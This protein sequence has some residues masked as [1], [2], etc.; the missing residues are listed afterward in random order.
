MNFPQTLARAIRPLVRPPLGPSGLLL[1]VLFAAAPA[2]A[3]ELPIEVEARVDQGQIYFGENVLYQVVVQNAPQSPAPDLSALEKDFAIERAG[4]Q[5][6]VLNSQFTQRV[7]YGHSYQYRL[8]PKRAGRLTIAAPTVTFEGRKY[9]G[10][11]L[12]LSVIAPEVQDL[13]LVELAADA[14]RAFPSLPITLTV[15][16]LLKPLAEGMANEPLPLMRPPSL[17]IPWLKKAPA[18]MRL[19]EEP[20]KLLSAYISR[21]RRGVALDG[22]VSREEGLFSLFDE[23][24]AVV[25]DLPKRREKR[26]GLDGQEYQYFVYEL[27]VSYVPEK[28]GTAEF[29]PVSVRGQFITGLQGRRYLGKEL[30]VLSAALNVE[31]VDMLAD[32]GRPA[33]FTGAYGAL[34]LRAS[35]QPTSLRVRDPL[36]LQLDVLPKHPGVALD[37]VGPPNITLQEDLT[38]NFEII[39]EQ[40]VGTMDQGVKRFKYGLRPKQPGSGLP[41]IAL[42]YFDTQTLKYERVFSNPVDLT[43]AQATGLSGVEVLAGARPKS[44]PGALQ[45]FEGGIYQNFTDLAMLDD[46]HADLHAY[47]ALPALLLCAYV[48]VRL[49]LKRRR[50]LT[51]DQALQRRQRAWKEARRRLDAASAAA[52]SSAAP[53]MLRAALLGLVADLHNLPEAGLTPRDAVTALRTRGAEEGA[54]K[55]LLSVLE[56][57]ETMAYG[58]ARAEDLKTLRGRVLALAMRLDREFK[59]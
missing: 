10:N 23:R 15:R 19:K 16:L 22:F 53:G 9:A 52:D 14:P 40:P 38:R 6:L 45:R 59:A 33:D 8:T 56:G 7:S 1:C 47:A 4:D 41:P 37:L 3:E 57:L 24:K 30:L 29:K 21:D 46:R 42:S 2:L 17:S 25:L 54:R 55:E 49:L 13:A 34:E 18:G 12:T 5:T 35:A 51:G 50:R 43:V 44:E 27:K 36:T 32:P 31:V 28:P 11:S 39:D 48:G 26:V 20:S 58:G